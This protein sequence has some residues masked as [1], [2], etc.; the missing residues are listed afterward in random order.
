MKQIRKISIGSNYK[1]SAMHYS[2]GQEV[3]GGHRVS[4]IIKVEAGY[5]IIIRKDSVDKIWKT[6][7]NCMAIALEYRLDL[8]DK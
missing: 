6:F 1:D 3:Y 8:Q 4:Q 7:N 2:I 5:D